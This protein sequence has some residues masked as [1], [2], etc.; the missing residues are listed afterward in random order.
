LESLNFYKPLVE[1]LQVQAILA[2][3]QSFIPEF[4]TDLER[5]LNN[6]SSPIL[7]IPEPQHLP[8]PQVPAQMG[9]QMAPQV[10]Q[11][12]TQITP[13]MGSQVVPQMPV[14]NS[15]APQVPATPEDSR[16]QRKRKV[17]PPPVE[18][19]SPAVRKKQKQEEA[20]PPATD[21]VPSYLS[22]VQLSTPNII[23]KSTAPGVI[24]VPDMK[25]LTPEVISI[26]L[27]CNF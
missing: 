9:H 20:P 15:N 16:A 22:V 5:E 6:E 18:T 13:Q 26:I 14:A 8:K 23:S 24:Q 19:S 7:V 27:Y 21:T 25:D 11:G 10:A 2:D 1:A 3:V 4:F 17:N 12:A